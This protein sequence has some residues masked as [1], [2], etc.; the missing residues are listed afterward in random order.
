MIGAET[1]AP[2][3]EEPKG[4]TSTEAR[5]LLER[6][7]PNELVPVAERTSALAFTLR[8][9]ADPMVLLLLGAAAA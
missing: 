9:A 3:G 1:I 6:V 8:L 7:G 2:V 5:Q 4:L